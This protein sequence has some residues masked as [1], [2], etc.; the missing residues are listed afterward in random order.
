MNG[1]KG[2]RLGGWLDGVEHFCGAGAQALG[3]EHG[4]CGYGCCHWC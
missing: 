4:H 2:D 1:E 3:I